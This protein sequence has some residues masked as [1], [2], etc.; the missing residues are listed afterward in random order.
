LKWREDLGQVLTSSDHCI[1][2]PE[3]SEAV[4]LMA[5]G[6]KA[7]TKTLQFLDTTAHEKTEPSKQPP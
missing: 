7:V 2:V 5:N 3:V 6:A 4:E 1:T